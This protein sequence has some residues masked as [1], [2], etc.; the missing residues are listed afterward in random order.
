MESVERTL[1]GL[2]W[3]VLQLGT[4]MGLAV[5]MLVASLGTL[6]GVSPALADPNTWYVDGASGSDTGSCGTTVAPCQTISHTL[7]ARASASDTLRIAQG[8]YTENLT[9]NISVT[10]EGGYEASGWTRDLG[11]YETILDGSAGGGM[12]LPWDARKV[13]YPM[14]ITDGTTYK[15]WYNGYDIYGNM[16]IG[17]ATSPDGLT[18][19]KHPANP[20]LDAGAP[21]AWDEKLWE[22]PFVIRESSTSYK[23]WYGG[24]GPAGYGIGYATSS[25]GITWTKHP[26]NPVLSPGT[27]VWNNAGVFHPFVVFE[28]GTYRMWL[29][30]DGN[31]GSG[32]APTMAYATSP[33]GIAWTW[34]TNY[35]FAR[36][37]EDWMWRPDVLHQGSSYYMWYSVW[38]LN[39]AH[40]SYA[41]SSD[42]LA[43]AKHGSPVLS[44]TDGE[45]DDD[46]V[47]DPFVYFDGSIYTM[48]Y[49][50]DTAIGVVTSTNGITWTKFLTGPILT[51][52]LPSQS[53]QPVVRLLNDTVDLVLDGLTITGG[54]GDQAG[55]VHAHDGD[56]TI[57][58]SLIRDNVANGAPQSWGAGGVIAGTGRLSI[59]DS[60]IVNNRVIE[61]AGGVR[62]GDGTLV[63][64]NTLVAANRGDAGLHLNGAGTLLNA[65]IANN[66]GGIIYNPPVSATLAITNSIIYH[67]SPWAI[68]SPGAGTVEANYSDI[69]GGWSGTGNLDVDPA[70]ADPATGNYHLTG[71]SSCIDQGV[72]Q[73]APDHD[74]EQ[75]P[76][77]QDGD[78]DGTATTDMG[79]YEFKLY[80]T[81]L[82]LVVKNRAQ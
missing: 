59:L 71:N 29:R 9:I 67:N 69:E 65:T 76:R 21:G 75:T 43:W 32:D 37:W 57:R 64:S 14:V 53:G 72:D 74:L 11:A 17:Y 61:G 7:N 52:S 80:S 51:R 50:D 36:D 82:P 68:G 30:S 48:W 6:R 23:M 3:L 66:D 12:E 55:G 18:W 47:A 1:P 70:L 20:V 49:D 24:L 42:G 5:L 2:R 78:L 41:T 81:Y 26:G 19:T 45:W 79:A 38:R 10:L 40:I 16:R 22:A 33:D 34:H 44:G 62:V 31:D 54:A 25:D 39:E 8:T 60:R 27:A 77:P 56:V 4:A 13:R 28:G 35:L 46:F 63:L 73:G 15:M 58:N